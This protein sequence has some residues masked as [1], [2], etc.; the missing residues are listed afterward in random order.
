MIKNKVKGYKGKGMDGIIAR[1]YDKSAKEHIMEQYKI[2]VQELVKLI[3]KKANV[4]EVASGPG[5]LSIELV[6]TGINKITGMDISESFIEISKNNAK[7]AN[8]QIEFIKGNV[9]NMQF[10]DNKFTHIICTSAFKN[11]SDPLKA[12]KEMHRVL[13]KGGF[14]WLSD[15][16]QDVSNLEIDKYVNNMMKLKGFNSLITKLTFKYMLRKRAYTK[17]GI[18][19]L[20]SKTSFKVKS[21]K[22]NT[23][24]FYLLLQK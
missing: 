2:W 4:L 18:L 24:E 21:F 7:E 5:Y 20:A 12:L 3:P 19:E 6:K 22:Q 13:I 9:S 8:V 11:F 14:V 15:M 17:T 10:E 16:R 23:L 1:F